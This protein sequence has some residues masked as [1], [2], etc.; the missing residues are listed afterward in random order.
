MTNAI[1]IADSVSTSSSGA[2]GQTIWTGTPTS[3]SVATF[4]APS[5]GTVAIDISGTWAGTLSFE[6]SPDGVNFSAVDAM[7]DG[8]DTRHNPLRR[9][10]C[11][12]SPPRPTIRFA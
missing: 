9:M 11:S 3:G 2:N 5:A 1:T 12:K 6:E 7:Q 10:G 8:V 4:S